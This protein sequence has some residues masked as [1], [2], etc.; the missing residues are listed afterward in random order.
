[1]KHSAA[2]VVVAALVVTVLAASAPAAFAGPYLNDVNPIIFVHG[3]A[4][5]ASQFESQAMRFTSNGYRHQY[6]NALEYD[7]TF[8][9]NT[10]ADVFANLD[11]LI[12]QAKEETGHRRRTG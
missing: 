4:G 9:L 5:S 2:R 3:G 8:S 11:Q 1:M 12:A 10:T 6:I 7:S